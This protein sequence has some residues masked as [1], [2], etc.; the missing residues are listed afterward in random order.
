MFYKHSKVPK[1]LA[2]DST[3]DDFFLPFSSDCSTFVHADLFGKAKKKILKNESGQGFDGEVN[4]SSRKVQ[5]YSPS[6]YEEQPLGEFPIFP[7]SKF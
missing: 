4:A 7:S 5:G 6:L 1:F 3:S 2:F